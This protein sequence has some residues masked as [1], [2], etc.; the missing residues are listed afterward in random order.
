[1]PG[2]K[3]VEHVLAETIDI[4]G[5]T[6]FFKPDEAFKETFI[7][8]IEMLQLRDGPPPLCRVVLKCNVLKDAN[9]HAI[10]GDFLSGTLPTG[11]G[12]AGGDFESWFTL[13]R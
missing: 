7:N 3:F 9:D 6:A 11:D 10:D 12:T 5:D 4:T 1:M 2:T 13:T 8:I